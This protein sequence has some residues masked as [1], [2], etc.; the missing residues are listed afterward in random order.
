L[1]CEAGPQ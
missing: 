1:V